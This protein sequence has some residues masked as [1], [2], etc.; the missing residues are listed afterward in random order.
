M[1]Y[2]T[3]KFRLDTKD[4]GNIL[5]LIDPEKR[6]RYDYDNIDRI[7][8]EYMAKKVDDSFAVERLREVFGSS[9][10][11]VLVPGASLE[12][13]RDKVERYIAARCPVIVSVNFVSG[14]ERAYSF[15]GNQKRYTLLRSRRKGGRTIVSSNVRPDSGSGDIVVNYHSVIER[16]HRFA[17]NSTVMLLNLLKRLDAKR[18]AIAGLDGFDPTLDENYADPSFQNERH[19]HEFSELN[20]DL[21]SMLA[22]IKNELS[23]RCELLTITPGLFEGVLGGDADDGE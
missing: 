17:D 18:I 11:L 23:G 4:I 3:S 19:A 6:Q 10:V 8:A 2:L 22:E 9:E 16:G 5:S 21:A 7:Y 20:E 14:A 15:F 13:C 12:T 1:I